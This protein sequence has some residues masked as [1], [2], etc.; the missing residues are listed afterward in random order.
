MSNQT[1][2]DWKDL[3]EGDV[4]EFQYKN[5][6]GNTTYISEVT[7]VQ[8]TI[9]TIQDYLCLDEECDLEIWDMNY[10]AENVL[11]EDFVI[12]R[13]LFERPPIKE[14]LKNLFPEYFL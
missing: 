14:T 5:E 6:E 8:D 4:F 10:E 7:K 11:N 1:T 12:V 9:L 3:K 13:F 2:K